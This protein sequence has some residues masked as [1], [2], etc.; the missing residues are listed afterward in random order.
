[1]VRLTRI[2][3]RHGD[4]GDTHLGD[5]SRVRKTS[6]RVAAYGDVDELNA[7]IGVARS[8]GLGPEVDGWLAEVQNDLFDLGADLSVP[9]E[10]EGGAGRLRIAPSQVERLERW[11]DAANA[12]L[13][14]LTSFVLPAGSPAAA[15]LH[16]ARTVCRRAERSA[17][18]LADAEPVGPAALAYLNRLSDLLFILARRAN[19]DAGGDVLWAPGEGRAP[20]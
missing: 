2:Y 5:M 1:V 17:V 7:A 3:T 6:A 18:A 11:C 15:A 19:R 16:L 14:T 12:A 20:Q 10:G 4:A 13:P 8:H 9:E